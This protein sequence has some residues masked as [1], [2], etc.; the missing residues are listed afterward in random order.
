MNEKIIDDA[1]VDE[2][3]KEVLLALNLN[4]VKEKKIKNY[5]HQFQR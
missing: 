2:A 4:M 5:K 1:K 3:K